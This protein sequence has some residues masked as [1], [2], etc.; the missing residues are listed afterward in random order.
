M[1][2]GLDPEFIWR[3]YMGTISIVKLICVRNEHSLEHDEEVQDIT[4]T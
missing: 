2:S 1:L 4:G 3:I